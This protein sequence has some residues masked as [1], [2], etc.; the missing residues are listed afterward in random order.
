[1]SQAIKPTNPVV[2]DIELSFGGKLA[3]MM[4]VLAPML[5]ALALILA[6]LYVGPKGL[7]YEGALAARG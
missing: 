5:L 7:L 4:P 2:G 1:M 6:R 3:G